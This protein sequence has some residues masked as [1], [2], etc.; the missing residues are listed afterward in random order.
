M[1]STRNGKHETLKLNMHAELVFNEF[2]ELTQS[3]K[4]HSPP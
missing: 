3:G 1:N 2:L 4:R